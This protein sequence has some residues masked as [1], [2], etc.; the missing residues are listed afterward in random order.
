MDPRRP[1]RIMKRISATEANGRSRQLFDTAQVRV[2]G[3]G[4]V[5]EVMMSIERHERLHCAGWEKAGDDDG[6]RW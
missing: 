6:R 1:V 2:T 5:V 3:S 4:M